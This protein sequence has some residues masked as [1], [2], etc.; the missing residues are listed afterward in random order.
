VEENDMRKFLG[1][2]LACAA[3]TTGGSA[4]AQDWGRNYDD[5][6]RYERRGDDSRGS[7]RRI[8]SGQRGYQLERR[9]RRQDIERYTARRMQNS[10]DALQNRERLVCAQR[11]AREIR[12]LDARYDTLD[13]WM[14]NATRDEYRRRW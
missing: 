6:G 2:V 9:L 3:V 12:L 11:D 13:R 10:L 1:A 5:G 4:Y 7:L 14:D 8:C